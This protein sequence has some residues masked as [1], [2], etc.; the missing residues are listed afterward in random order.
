MTTDSVFN[1]IFE[2]SLRVLV[3]LDEADIALD[4]ET[5]VAVDF[6]AT[7]GKVFA[8]SEVSAN[9]D[10][11][12]LFCELDSRRRLVK[13]AV[14]SLVLKGCVIPTATKKGF[15]YRLLLRGRQF[16]ESLHSSYSREYREAV[17]RALETVDE[18]GSQALFAAIDMKSEL[19]VTEGLHDERLFD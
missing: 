5:I 6:V 7:Y 12:L 15:V 17:R 10:N 2:T 19:L 4:T 14:K 3:L 11:A 16:A 18:K 13:D 8:L 9:G 1:T